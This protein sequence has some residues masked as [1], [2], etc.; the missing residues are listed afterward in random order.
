MGPRTNDRRRIGADARAWMTV[1]RRLLTAGSLATICATAMWAAFASSAMASST[2]TLF[3]TNANANTI[4]TAG[5]DGSGA[6]ESLISGAAAPVGVAVDRQ[7]VYWTNIAGTSIGRANLDGSGATQSFITGAFFPGG[8]AVDGQHIYWSNTGTGAI[9][10]A[11]LDGSGVNQNFITGASGPVALAVDGAHI[12][13]ANFGN[14]GNGTTIGEAN[15]DGTGVN[16]NYITGARGPFGVAVDGGHVYWTNS[17]TLGDGTTIGRANLDGTGVNQ[18]FITGASSPAGVADDGQHLYWSNLNTGTI[19]VANL[20]G[21]GVNQQLIT[22]AH[23]P[24]G[25]AVTPATSGP[26]TPVAQAISFPGSQV[27]YGQPDFS[28]A[29]SDSGLFVTYSNPSGNC[30]VTPQDLVHIT[31]AGSCT[32]TASQPGNSQYLAATPVTR[33][34]LIGPATLSVNAKNASTVFGQAAS[35]SYDLSGFVNAEFPA[36]AGVTGTANCTLAAGAG[37]DAGSYPAAITCAPGTLAAANYTFVTGSSGTLTITKAPQTVA[38]TS[39]PPTH[40]LVGGTYPLSATGGPSGA[41]VVFAIDPAST[42]N[43]CS[44]AGALVSFTGSGSCVVDANQAGTSN[45][46]AAPQVQ[47]TITV[48]GV[49]GASDSFGIYASGPSGLVPSP[50][51]SGSATAILNIPYGPNAPAHYTSALLW[52]DYFGIPFLISPP[53]TLPDTGQSSLGGTI[54]LSFSA[55]GLPWGLYHLNAILWNA[56]GQSGIL[57]ASTF[58]LPGL[59]PNCTSG[60]L[61]ARDARATAASRGRGTASARLQAII[62]RAHRAGRA[63]FSGFLRIPARMRARTHATAHPPAAVTRAE[64]SLRRQIS[65]LR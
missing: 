53:V 63:P 10:R 17:G 23:G 35:L 1:R 27:S 26:A 24:A 64:A 52:V 41:P 49:V 44:V 13:W 47:Q 38:F 16:E 4:G 34:F 6:N 42:T 65:R 3:W 59:N 5:V 19:G 60:P 37:P 25:L 54:P 48:F 20:D 2:G 8:I 43:A 18:S 33:T 7:Y 28:P 31:G 21:S 9:G 40:P 14:G 11:N 55:A 56:S 61:V 58:Y 51:T 32:V 12:Y 50:C 62:R 30:T 36:S 29:S 57:T 22:G 39:T 46:Q 45:Y 15:L